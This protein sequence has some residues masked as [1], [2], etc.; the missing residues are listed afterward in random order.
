MERLGVSY[1]VGFGLKVEETSRIT[2]A[3]YEPE[4]KFLHATGFLVHPDRSIVVACYSSGAIGRLVAKDVLK[5]VKY[6]KSL[7]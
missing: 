6:Y 4:K 3:F 5:L 2:G 7:K 1:P